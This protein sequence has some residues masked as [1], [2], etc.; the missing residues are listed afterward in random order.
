MLT[1]S[2]F[3]DGSNTLLGQAEQIG[4][5]VTFNTAPGNQSALEVEEIAVGALGAPFSITSVFK[6]KHIDVNDSTS[7]DATHIA[8]V[9][10]PASLLLLL[11]GLLGLGFLGR[12]RSNVVSTG[13]A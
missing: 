8:A 12:N 2:S 5:D 13:T 4:S 10:L 9:P 6:V 1:A 3:V 11:T 7:F